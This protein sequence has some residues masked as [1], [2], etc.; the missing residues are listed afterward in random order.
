MVAARIFT[1]VPE[2]SNLARGIG[3][4]LTA[5][6]DPLSAI[7]GLINDDVLRLVPIGGG[8]VNQT[9]SAHTARGRMYFAKFH[10]TPPS[11][12]FEVE[13]KSLQILANANALAT[14]KPV[15]ANRHCLLMEFIVA[16]SPSPNFWRIFG[17]RLAG[18]HKIHSGDF[19]LD[20]DTWCGTTPQINS[21]TND[22]HAFF[23][24]HRLLM[25][26]R[27]ANHNG[28]FSTS[29]VDMVERLCAKL[30]DLI[31]VQP[32][33]L[34][35]GD[36]WS[37]N[38][39]IG[40]NGEPVIFDPATYY[41]WREAELAMTSLFGGYPTEFYNA[42]NEHYPMEQGWEERFSL[43]NL[44]PILNHLNLFGGGYYHQAQALLAK[45]V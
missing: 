19:G 33:S 18:L 14:P 13:S 23:A 45:Y 16:G 43:Y 5:F 41:G 22:G 10:P 11:G 26:A 40:T 27:L 38:F 32:A 29:E 30:R 39:L 7:N 25:Q 34:L 15:A 37:G 24:E 12:M 42:Y 31:P 3:K 35:H 36:L 21:P 20:F 9:F 44:Y 6:M 4:A 28:L 17:H 8:C 2:D 1:R